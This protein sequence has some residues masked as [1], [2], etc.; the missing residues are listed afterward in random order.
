MENTEIIKQGT[1]EWHRQRLGKFT[2]STFANVMGK[3]KKKDEK[4]SIMAMTIIKEKV[5]Q[6]LTD[7]YAEISGAALEWG[8]ENEPIAIKEYE[9]LTG[10][11]VNEAPFVPLKGY[12]D[13]AGGSPDGFVEG[14][15]GI[16]EVKCPYISG[17]HIEALIQK[18]IPLKSWKMYHT[19]MQFNML[20]TGSEF[21]DFI[22]YDPRI[23]DEEKRIFVKRIKR[24]EGIIA[25]IIIRLDEAILELNRILNNI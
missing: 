14:Q 6:R 12:E 9:E 19:Q 25:E 8:T 5:A 10:F 4:F 23:I 11:K 20:C 22:S 21:C 24:D 2:A 15:K 3:G 17:N 16:I 1:E 18:N 13:Y 7:T